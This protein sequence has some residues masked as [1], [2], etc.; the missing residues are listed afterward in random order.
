MAGHC[1]LLFLNDSKKR[2]NHV[3]AALY[4]FVNDM[5]RLPDYTQRNKNKSWSVYQSVNANSNPGVL[6]FLN[7]IRQNEQYRNH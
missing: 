2:L 4:V 6:S 3:F 7:G 5:T 1:N